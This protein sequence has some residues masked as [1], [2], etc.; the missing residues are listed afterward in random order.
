VGDVARTGDR[1]MSRPVYFEGH[2]LLVQRRLG[3]WQWSVEVADG[4]SVEGWTF[5]K[6]GAYRACFAAVNERREAGS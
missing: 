2:T 5:S 6:R 1:R 3:V 4:T